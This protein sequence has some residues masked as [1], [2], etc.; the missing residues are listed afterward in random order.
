MLS[1][2]TNHIHV[3][4]T[5]AL[6]TK[7]LLVDICTLEDS[8]CITCVWDRNGNGNHLGLDLQGIGFTTLFASVFMIYFMS[9]QQK[10]PIITFLF[11]IHKPF[12]L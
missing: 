5:C 9:N 8:N 6:V 7:L 1:L 11:L 2:D 12:L 4:T 3:V 10:L